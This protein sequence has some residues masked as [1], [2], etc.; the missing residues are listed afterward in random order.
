MHNIILGFVGGLMVKTPPT[1]ARDTEN[2]GLIPKS[3][4]SPRGGNGNL[5][6]YSYLENSMDRGA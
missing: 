6:C 1:N 3:R 2:S 4:R 5:L